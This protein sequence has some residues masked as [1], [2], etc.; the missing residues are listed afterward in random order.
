M[1]CNTID[2]LHDLVRWYKISHAE[3]QVTQWD[4]QNKE[5]SSWT[6]ASCFVLDV[7]LCNMR[8]SMAD[9]VPCDRVVQWA[10]CVIA[11]TFFPSPAPAQLVTLNSNYR[12]IFQSLSSRFLYSPQYKKSSS[13]RVVNQSFR[14]SLNKSRR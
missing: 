3:T 12:L 7:P 6:G 5:K 10:H 13:Q 1:Q 11:V 9:L 14:K 2:P 4:S 8:P